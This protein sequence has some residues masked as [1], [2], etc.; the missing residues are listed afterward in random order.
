[1]SLKYAASWRYGILT[2]PSLAAKRAARCDSTNARELAANPRWRSVIAFFAQFYGFN[3]LRAC[4]KTEQPA[5]KDA[6]FRA[7]LPARRG[8]AASRIRL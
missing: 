6:C 8:T 3:T 2:Q 7:T 4:T 1:M 5:T